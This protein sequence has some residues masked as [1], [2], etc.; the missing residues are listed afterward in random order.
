MIHVTGAVSL[1]STLIWPCHMLKKAKSC[2]KKTWT[3]NAGFLFKEDYVW[4]EPYKWHAPPDGSISPPKV[5][6]SSARIGASLSLLFDASRQASANDT[7][8]SACA[9]ECCSGGGRPGPSTGSG[10][11]GRLV[12]P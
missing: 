2:V 12:T 3:I 11:A 7:T 4:D 5:I 10:Q 6:S 8:W 1:M 9:P